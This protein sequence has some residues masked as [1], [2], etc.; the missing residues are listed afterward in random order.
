M[1]TKLSRS[2]MT[3]AWAEDYEWGWEKCMDPE[4]I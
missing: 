1:A 2:E 3:V 4:Y